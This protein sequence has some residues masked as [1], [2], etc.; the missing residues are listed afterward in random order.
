MS[1]IPALHPPSVVNALRNGQ[2]PPG[3]DHLSVEIITDGEPGYILASTF[4][5]ATPR[6][7]R[8]SAGVPRGGRLHSRRLLR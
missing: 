8:G 7:D 4:R 1:P 3:H 6:G 2:L 5:D